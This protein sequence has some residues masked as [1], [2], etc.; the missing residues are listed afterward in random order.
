MT[1]R[2]HIPAHHAKAHH[3]LAVFAQERRN[4]GV[5]GT[6]AR[7]DLV[8]PGGQA[9]ATA[10]VLQADAEFGLDA[11]RAKTHVVALDEAHHHAVFIG[12]REVNRAALDRVAG[13]KVLCFFHVD[14]FGTGGEVGVV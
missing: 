7:C 8:G 5:K 11:T 10:P 3:R 9:E 1:L 14:E 6:L 13:A 12:C 4:D 2:L